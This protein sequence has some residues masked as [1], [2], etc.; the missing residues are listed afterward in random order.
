MLFFIITVTYFSNIFHRRGA[1]S[2]KSIHFL[3][4]AERAANKKKDN[5]CVLCD[6]YDF[7]Y[8]PKAASIL[9]GVRGSS[10][11]LTPMPLE[12]CTRD[13]PENFPLV[14]GFGSWSPELYEYHARLSSVGARSSLSNLDLLTI[15]LSINLL[16]RASK[17]KPHINC[18]NLSSLWVS[19][20]RMEYN[21]VPSRSNLHSIHPPGIH[22]RASTPWPLMGCVA[23]NPPSPVRIPPVV[24]EQQ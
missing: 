24:K 11:K 20:E 22:K 8:F 3:F 16:P 19:T 4:A 12:P 6:L 1:E 5:L 13:T 7:N 23:R 2:A 10:I 15:Q 21:H 9:S 14:S 17:R 18:T